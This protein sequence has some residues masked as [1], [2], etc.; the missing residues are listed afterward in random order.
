MKEQALAEEIERGGAVHL[1]LERLQPIDVHV[2]RPLAP[3]RAQGHAHGGLIAAQAT[4]EVDQFGD[5]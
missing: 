2:N 5:A 4:R 1:P 3:V